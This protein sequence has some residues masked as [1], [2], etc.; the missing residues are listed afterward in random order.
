MK[1]ITRCMGILA[2]ALLSQA[3][4]WAAVQISWTDASP[5]NSGQHTVIINSAVTNP[6]LPN[7]ENSVE[8]KLAWEANIDVY[9]D[10]AHPVIEFICSGDFLVDDFADPGV[11][12][13]VHIYQTVHNETS[14]AWQGFELRCSDPNPDP[15]TAKIASFYNIRDWEPH[16]GD[17]WMDTQYT[18]YFREA[19]QP[20]VEVGGT[21]Y[22]TARIF[23]DTDE[24]GLGGFI[25]TKN[26]IPAVP[27]PGSCLALISGLLGLAGLAR[28]KL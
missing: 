7:D 13:L 25:L 3:S 19:G 24:D 18:G 9:I 20:L 4:V 28:K 21:F 2:L 11:Y 15:N 1:P 8:Y 6:Y 5:I 26:A 12:K 16:W 17:V 14:R 27:E 23:A 10:D 22:D